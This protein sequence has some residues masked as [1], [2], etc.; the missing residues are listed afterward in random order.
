[1]GPRGQP[2][3]YTTDAGR[4]LEVDVVHART[5]LLG[6]DVAL[7]PA[8]LRVVL[9]VLLAVPD[10]VGYERRADD[11][12]ARLGLRDVEAVEDRVDLVALE[13]RVDAVLEQGVARGRLERRDAVV[14]V[15]RDLDVAHVLGVGDL[16]DERAAL[17]RE[18]V[19]AGDVRLVDDEHG[20]LVGEEG[21]DGVE[22]LALGLDRVPALLGEIHEV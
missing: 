5:A 12:V 8:P 7:E 13:L 4:T 18:V 14:G 2:A 3:Q 11:V 20:G 10:G 22:E 15:A 17:R 21:L 1:M 16:V 9:V 19:E 6:L